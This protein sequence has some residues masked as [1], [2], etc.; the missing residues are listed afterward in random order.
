MLAANVASANTVASST[1]YFQ[2]TLTDNG[3]GTYT[4]VIA[5]INEGGVDSGY[6]IY[7]EEGATAWFGNDPGSGPVWTSQAIGADHDGWPTWTPDTP[8]WYQYSLNLYVD[9]GQQKW[10]VR[11]HPGA[12]AT[13]PWDDTV[14]WGGSGKPPAGVPLSGSMLWY[15]D[16]TGGYAEETDVG[17]YLPATGTPEIPGGAAGYGGGPHAWDMDWSW[18]S[19]VVPLEFPGFELEV[20]DLGGGVREST[21]PVV[22]RACD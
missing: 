15:S 7:G 12:T 11:N 14:F 2:G 5:M 18:G 19:E 13:N 9:G 4:G 10:A 6:D 1:M 20:T 22:T 21:R 8:D 17:A 3:D 16:G